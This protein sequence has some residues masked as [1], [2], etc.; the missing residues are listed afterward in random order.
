[1]NL[2]Y[3]KLLPNFAFN[4]KLS[5]YIKGFYSASE[6]GGGTGAAAAGDWHHVALVVDGTG[7][8]AW[9]DADLAASSSMT[10]V[11]RCRLNR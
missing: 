6:F 10:M 1:M 5:P 4:L 11:R 7:A 2:N 8:T 3:D 9:I